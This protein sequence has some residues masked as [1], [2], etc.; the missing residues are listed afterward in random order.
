MPN[1][2]NMSTYT[3]MMRV[4]SKGRPYAK[5]LFDLFGALLIQVP[6]T[7]HRSLLRTYPHTFTTDEAV[8]C[9]GHLE[10]THLVST[11]NPLDPSKP[12][13]TRTT[14]TFSMSRAIAKTLGQHFINARLVENATDPQNRTMKDR[15]IW[16]PTSKGK[17]VIRDF[18]HRA[19]ISIKHM[20]THLSHIQTFKI[21]QFERLLEDDQIAFSRP[22]MMDAFKTM[23]LYMPTDNLMIDDV[24]G[25]NNSNLKEYKDTFY[26]H[27][28]LEW[29]SEYT[30]AVSEDEAIAIAAEFVQYGWMLQVFDKSDRDLSKRD[31]SVLFKAGRRTQYYLTDKGRQMIDSSTRLQS[32]L[33]SGSGPGMH[34]SRSR[35]Q[36]SATTGTTSSSSSI[37]TNNS[38]GS[39]HKSPFRSKKEDYTSRMSPT[40][41]V[42]SSTN[43]ASITPKMLTAQHA[44][45]PV[46]QP[47]TDEDRSMKPSN[48]AFVPGHESNAYR[49]NHTLVNEASFST[50]SE[51]EATNQLSQ[52]SVGDTTEASCSLIADQINSHSQTVSQIARLQAILEDPL[53][54]MY[55][56]NFLKKNFCEENINFWVDY[57]ALIKKSGCIVEE[58]HVVDF[59]YL[60]LSSSL[61]NVLLVYGLAIYNTYFCPENAPSE[62]NIDH[63]LRY[64]II[65]YIQSTFSYASLTDDSDEDAVGYRTKKTTVADSSNVPF[66]SISVSSQGI[67]SSA[68]AMPSYNG[69]K[70][71]GKRP[72]NGNNGSLQISIKEGIQDSPQDCLYKLVQLY[73]QVNDHVCR[74]MAQ[75]S[76]PRFLKTP[77]YKEFMKSCYESAQNRKKEEEESDEE[78]YDSEDTLSL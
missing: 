66:G 28:C 31:R 23:M 52:L 76:V 12:L 35:T 8:E 68:I 1:S 6:L 17:Y 38:N 16:I 22:N 63:G 25:V 67:V 11:P 29:I 65:Q 19:C 77:E 60:Q 20:Q 30:S 61:V 14:T 10:F 54:R 2:A 59:H 64:D 50:C 58:G 40:T 53:A 78:G 57:N 39:G 13:I 47:K 24:G 55:F 51:E 62:L 43:Y 37:K 42:V 18:S 69:K 70:K 36:S 56:R 48:N 33:S 34:V 46:S 49:D 15:G 45:T 41:A 32:F 74:T 71:D 73:E 26:G 27:Q 7:D 72:I 44:T 21:V 5:E 9:L 3:T 4:N 75:D